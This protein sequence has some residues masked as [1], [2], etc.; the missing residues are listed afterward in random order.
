MKAHIITWTLSVLSACI[1]GA[2]WV[3]THPSPTKIAVVEL[4]SILRDE[5][6]K[7]DKEIKPDMTEQQKREI[8][9]RAEKMVE[10]VKLATEQVGKECDCTIFTAAAVVA[11]GGKVQD[12]TWRVKELVAA[13]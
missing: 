8:A 4:E 13:R 9:G 12:L 7:L 10:R 3:Y 6:L 5:I 2:A 11:N 1:I